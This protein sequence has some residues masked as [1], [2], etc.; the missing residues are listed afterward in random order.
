MT[1]RRSRPTP[2]PT[3]TYTTIGAKT[4]VLT[5]TDDSGA[6]ATSSVVV[7]PT[8]NQAPTAVANGTPLRGVFPLA[9]NFSSA[10]SVDADCSLGGECP[11][12]SYSWDFG[13]G[14]AASTEADPSHL[15]EDPDT[16]TATLTVTDNEGATAT[17]SVSVNVR[18]PNLPPLVAAA[19]TPSSGKEPLTVEFS[20]AGSEDQEVDGSI[21]T[22]A[23]DFGDGETS[24]SP[25][26]THV[27]Q[28]A[29]TYVATLTVTDNDDAT[30]TTTVVTTVD[31]NQSPTAVAGANVT[32][33]H[34]PLEVDFT[35]A[36]SL[37]P[38]G[39]FDVSWDFGDGATS[40][41][42]DP[43]HTY[44]NATSE[45]IVR[46]ATL[47]VTDDN[48]ATSVSTL[49][50]DVW[51][52]NQAPTADVVATPESGKTPLTVQFD[53]TASADADGTVST[54]EWDFDDGDTSSSA[55]PLHEFTAAGTYEVTLTVTDDD[56]A[57]D[58]ETVTI[59]AADNVAPIADAAVAPASGKATFTTFEF[60][61]SGSTDSDGTVAGYAWDF[62]DG[63]TGSGATPS[64][65]YAA[66][67]EYEVTLT[68]TDDNGAT[69]TATLTVSVAE[70][71]APTAAAAST[72]TAGKTNITT[73]QL[74][75]AGS[76]DSDGTIAGYSWDFGDG[77]PASSAENPTKVFSTAGV[78]PVTLTVT[79]DNGATDT[80]TVTI[81]VLD[82]VAPST[83]P[84][85]NLTS[86]TTATNF[87]FAA[88]AVDSD[89]T[90]TTYLWNFGN[91][92]FATTAN[93]SNKKFTAPGTY[94]VT[95]T[96]TDDNGA[97]TT[98]APITITIS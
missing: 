67:G 40:T 90:V 32:S 15:Y 22:Y 88:N 76:S 92:T 52:E 94:N 60:D 89:G 64:H 26:P 38:D 29:G 96:V 85:V 82:N 56:G 14:S 83:S 2:S 19:G 80:E 28:G 65:V 54:Y 44:T 55:S 24:S 20:S 48:G 41:E 97:Q 53:G 74:S 36:G 9:V 62:G 13:D 70:N 84:T 42:A 47:T 31:P 39:T 87:N 34:A 5:I 63:D 91:G 49:V 6:T 45:T 25:N 8:V 78:Y 72:P 73:F 7:T 86:G 3:H 68:V 43:T 4:A 37:D 21:V 66:A 59:T 81:T 18:L 17:S 77:S 79:D 57:T 95:V 69:D 71:V 46:T 10:G 27:Y 58:T 30:A 23:W 93:V 61:G 16:Y 1:A 98:S 12:L 35:S 75:S 11:G 50:I 51:P 33:G